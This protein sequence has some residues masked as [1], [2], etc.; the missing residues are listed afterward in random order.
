MDALLLRERHSMQY[1]QNE[2]SVKNNVILSADTAF[3]L[4]SADK[5]STLRKLRGMGVSIE[6]PAI[7]VSPRGDCFTDVLS[8]ERYAPFV[9]KMASLLDELV[10]ELRANIYFTPTAMH[11]DLYVINDIY[12]SMKRKNNTCV[13]NTSSMDPTE[14][15]TV[16]SFMDFLITMRLHAGILAANS[17]IPSVVIMP[18][19][20]LKSVGVTED[21]GL[22]DH[23]VSLGDP[24]STT[25]HM[26]G[27]VLSLHNHLDDQTDSLKDR[28]PKL[29]RRAELA[30]E[31]LQCFI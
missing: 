10:K 23:F 8:R 25:Q 15:E 11:E 20:D 4:M 29:Q 17:Y 2:M 21:I 19:Y 22:S 31:V 3:L 26:L 13:I 7:A 24:Q 30:G 1:L 28:I 18:S 27:K 12:R 16:L 14:V 6:K 9:Y 5:S